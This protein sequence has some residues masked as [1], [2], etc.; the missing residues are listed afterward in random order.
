MAA[1]PSGEEEVLRS[2][3]AGKQGLQCVLLYIRLST[4]MSLVSLILAERPDP[5]FP[6]AD[7]KTGD[8]REPFREP[9]VQPQT[10]DDFLA[11]EGEGSDLM[12]A[13]T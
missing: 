3:E 1:W 8:I 9:P 7:G 4:F 2:R 5:W 10:L 6:E 13:Q 12:C 11:R